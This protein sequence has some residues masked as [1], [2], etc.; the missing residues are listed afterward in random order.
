MVLDDAVWCTGRRRFR[1]TDK[2]EVLQTAEGVSV[3]LV[4][5][6]IVEQKVS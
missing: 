2:A 4:K 5:G 3:S 1:A 6:S